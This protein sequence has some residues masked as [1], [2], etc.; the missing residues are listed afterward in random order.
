[1]THGIDLK[2][3]GL[4]LTPES[5]RSIRES[6]ADDRARNGLTEYE[7]HMMREALKIEARDRRIHDTFVASL[8]IT[9]GAVVFVSACMGAVR[10]VDALWK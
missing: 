2:R 8:W 4:E 9:I 10:I 3:L 6:Q 1:M 7:M 5:R